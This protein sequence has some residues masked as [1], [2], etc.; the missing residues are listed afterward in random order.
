MKRV[1]VSGPSGS[2]KSALIAALVCEPL[3]CYMRNMMVLRDIRYSGP[4]EYTLLTCAP[5]PNVE[6]IIQ[7]YMRTDEEAA[8]VADALNECNVVTHVNGSHV[9]CSCEDVFYRALDILLN[10]DYAC[11]VIHMN[12]AAQACREMIDIMNDL[13]IDELTLSEVR[14][15]GSHMSRLVLDF[16]DGYTYEVIKDLSILPEIQSHGY[17]PNYLVVDHES[18]EVYVPDVDFTEPGLTACYTDVII[19]IFKDILNKL[20]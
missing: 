2:G 7:L 16:G 11:N 15:E 6:M 8:S 19:V 5:E 4:I 18:A 20:Y 3:R 10:S 1:K 14:D 13:D 12:I 9:T 17:I